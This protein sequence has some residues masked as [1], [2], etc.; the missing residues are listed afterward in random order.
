MHS[1][2]LI[3][4]QRKLKG[5]T[6]KQLAEAIGVSEPSIRL[7]ELGKRTPGEDVIRQIAE[8]LEVSPEALHAYDTDSAREVLEMLFRL[9]DDYGLVPYVSGFSYGLVVK[10][11]APKAKKLYPAID[12]WHGMREKLEGGAITKEEYDAWKA[13]FSGVEY[14]L[15]SL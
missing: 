8:A 6:Q 4:Q 15:V 9:E 7:Y 12:A 1:G 5:L 11:D 14:G 10:G 3:R 13:S 2:D